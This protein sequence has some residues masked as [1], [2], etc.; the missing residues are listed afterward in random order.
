[1]EWPLPWP[2]ELTEAL[3]AELRSKLRACGCRFQGLVPK[4][5]ESRRTI[6][7]YQGGCDGP[8]AGFRRSEVTVDAMEVADAAW[9]LLE[10]DGP[11][12]AGATSSDVLVCTHGRRGRCCGALGTELALG[13]LS[14]SGVLGT[15]TRVW[16]TSHTGGHRFA[17]TVL[18]FSEGT[19]WAF[20]DTA[21]L[22]SVVARHG[23]IR[24]VLSR[25]RGCPGLGS[26]RIQAVERAV[27]SEVGWG[28]FDMRR[29]G[30]EESD[31]TVRLELEPPTGPVITWEDAV[32]G[33]R[34]VALPEGGAQVEDHGKTTSELVVYWV[35]RSTSI[36]HSNSGVWP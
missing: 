30:S 21:L 11:E 36:P 26:P 19:G 8:F 17:P 25:Y 14:D 13:L 16:R 22:R 24:D 23:E 31:G 20:A 15:A 10:G 29:G 28:L 27:L 3:L 2:T 4:D 18:V 34:V 32:R 7:F 9:H 6:V 33:G 35:R 5:T 12:P 1:V